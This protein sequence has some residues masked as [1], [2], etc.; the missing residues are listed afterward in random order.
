MALIPVSL[1]FLG[2]LFIGYVFY[3][4]YKIPKK[5]RKKMKRKQKELRV[6]NL[7]KMVVLGQKRFPV[8][9]WL[10]SLLG[11]FVPCCYVQDVDHF[12]LAAMDKEDKNHMEQKRKKFQNKFIKYQ[13]LSSSTILVISIITIWCL[14]NFGELDHPK[15]ILSNIDLNIISVIL[16]V[17]YT[18]SLCFLKDIDLFEVFKIN[19]DDTTNGNPK[20]QF[21][22]KM[23]I[24]VVASLL[25]ICPLFIGLIISKTITD[26]DNPDSVIGQVLLC[27]A[28]E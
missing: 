26:N 4:T 5:I 20:W 27:G 12:F 15:N 18:F 14:V 2:N 19:Y 24:S 7:N 3:K 21:S 8:S 23:I 17:S 11:M 13:M 28:P 16:V 22:V 6:L 9:V 1:M 10:S 25:C